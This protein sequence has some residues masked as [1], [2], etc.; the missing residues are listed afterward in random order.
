MDRL[1]RNFLTT[2]SNVVHVEKTATRKM[3]IEEL[4]KTFFAIFCI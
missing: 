3:V 1:F 4:N 2:R